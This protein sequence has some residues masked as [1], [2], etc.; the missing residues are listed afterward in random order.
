MRALL[1]ILGAVLLIGGGYVLVRGM[2]VT[3]DREVL[4]VGPIEASV[5]EERAVPTWVGGLAA[6]AGLA[7]IIAGA[8]AKRAGA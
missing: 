8:S 5:E 4:D 7:M 1:L 2:S 3:T 6:A